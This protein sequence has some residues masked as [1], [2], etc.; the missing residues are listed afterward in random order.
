MLIKIACINIY[1][2]HLYITYIAMATRSG[3]LRNQETTAPLNSVMDHLNS[4]LTSGFFF[5]SSLELFTHIRRLKKLHFLETPEVMSYSLNVLF[6][7][8]K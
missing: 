8:S 6:G 5:N 3:V 7:I 2:E 1:L 4:N